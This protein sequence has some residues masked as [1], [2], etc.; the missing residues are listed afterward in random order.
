MTRRML[1][2]LLARLD[3]SPLPRT[4]RVRLELEA[5]LVQL[6]ARLERP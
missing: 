5:E 6:R 2:I 1:C 4:D 3:A